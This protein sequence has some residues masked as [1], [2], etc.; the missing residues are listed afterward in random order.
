MLRSVVSSEAPIS[1]KQVTLI[2]TWL[3]QI[4]SVFLI[5]GWLLITLLPNAMSFDA[6]I[7]WQTIVM[8][9]AL[10]FGPIGVVIL[11]NWFCWHSYYKGHYAAALSIIVVIVALAVIGIWGLFY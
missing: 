11:S 3:Y 2:V 6:G 1:F 10:T 9:L 7:Y 8:D 4:L 5:A